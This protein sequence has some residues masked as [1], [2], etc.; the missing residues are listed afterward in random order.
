MRIPAWLTA[1]FLL[2][3]G[4]GANAGD[5]P[6]GEALFNAACAHCHDR[7]LPRMPSRAGLAEKDPRDIYTAISAGVMAPYARALSH[8]QRRAVAEYAAG[9]SLGDFASGAAA[10]PASAYCKAK[11]AELLGDIDSGWNGW[12]NDLANT[13]YQD[14]ARGG[15]DRA[16]VMRLK[17]KWAFGV[18]AV[19]TMSGQPAVADGRLFFGTFSGLVVALDADSGCALWVF[20]ADGGVRTAI[21]LGTLPD[22]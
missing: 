19:S 13:R 3:G 12:G 10:I 21:T 4:A 17:L 16:S 18:P 6:D 14:V 22:G 1:M 8:E 2:L 15:I 9:E 7:N 20:E 11:P 5:T